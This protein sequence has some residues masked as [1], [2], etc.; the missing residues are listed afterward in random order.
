MWLPCGGAV[1]MIAL[2]NGELDEYLFCLAS[3]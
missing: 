1:L 3:G 2:N